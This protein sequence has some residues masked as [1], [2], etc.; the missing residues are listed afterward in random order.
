MER[1]P[2][3][4]AKYQNVVEALGAVGGEPGQQAAKLLLESKALSEEIARISLSIETLDD[5]ADKEGT[6]EARKAEIE[7]E[8]A[9]LKAEQEQA[10]GTKSQ[11]VERF[12][13]SV[14]AMEKLSLTGDNQA[15][16]AKLYKV[17]GHA[18]HIEL[19]ALVMTGV[20]LIQVP[21][22]LPNI[23][24]ELLA[25]VQRWANDALRKA[26][27]M[28]KTVATDSISLDVTSMSLSIDGID[29]DAIIDQ[30]LGDALAFFNQAFAAPGR[31]TS[32]ADSIEFQSDM[33]VS[34]AEI[35]AK[36]IGQSFDS[37]L[38]FDTE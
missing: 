38:S 5:E 24:N 37:D 26:G 34:L 29:S 13:S 2:K 31:V 22:A 7:K 33:L 18:A 4:E 12:S 30:L 3:S 27:N 21:R 8:V 9:A 32:I 36:L 11:L 14:D 25:L 10:E 19:E 16:M 6:T 20:V 23:H 17:I 35:S 15:L 1:R 28:A